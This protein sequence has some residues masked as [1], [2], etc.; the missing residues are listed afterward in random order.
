MIKYRQRTTIILLYI[1]SAFV[2]HRARAFYRTNAQCLR[3]EI[4]CTAERVG[5]MLKKV[6]KIGRTLISVIS[7]FIVVAVAVVILINSL[8]VVAMSKEDL[9]MSAEVGV[10][11]FEH[12]IEELCEEAV[13]LSTQFSTNGQVTG[14]MRSGDTSRLSSVFSSNCRDPEEV[15]ALFYNTT[16]QLVWKSSDTLDVADIPVPKTA[17]KDYVLG[18]SGTTLYYIAVTPVAGSGNI[19]VGVN[20][21]AGS[22]ID[23]IKSLVDAEVTVFANNVRLKTTIVD[24]NGDRVV[25]TTM[26]DEI[27]NI[28]IGK[29]QDYHGRA[30]ILGTPYYVM[31]EPI[32]DAN[33]NVVGALFAGFAAAESDATVFT[34]IIISAVVG[35]LVCFFAV[36]CITIFT[37][38]NIIAPVLA[39]KSL[40]DTMSR[41]ILNDEADLVALPK[42]E[43]GEMVKSLEETKKFL[44]G[45]ITDITNVMDAMAKGDFTRDAEIQ[46]LGNFEAI[47]TAFR[48]IQ[49]SLGEVVG[50]LND[51][52]SEVSS[53]SSQ[54]ANASQNLAEG[55]TR[56]AAA[57][58]NLSE[59]ISDI[60]DKIR[61][62]A[63][64]AVQ[65]DEYATDACS[66]VHIQAEYMDNMREA[67]NDIKIKS[68][69][70]EEIIKAIED[71]SFQTNIL[72]LNA[73]V[74]AARAGEAGKGF[75][76]VADEVRNLANK[77]NAATAQTAA[78][79]SETIA[80]VERGSEMVEK[81][82]ES[83]ADVSNIT[84]KTRDLI[85]KITGASTEQ[86]DAVH[87]V[88]AGISDIS[89][90]IQQNSATAEEIAASCQELSG[91]SAL[92][93]TQVERF[94]VNE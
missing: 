33:K 75:A 64:N 68:A 60:S 63:E 59:T 53:G 90:V 2:L 76:V 48:T 11:V 88:T 58:Q 12:R 84:E 34:T 41:G 89:D 32:Q 56:Q 91:Q 85:D 51:S 23:S 16:G 40:T 3:S 49:G 14:A 45:Y 10:K 46:Y 39:A 4:M 42:N 15:F 61:L 31:Y 21:A 92:L 72:A 29:A 71:I 74:E 8:R 44:S 35:L 80:A 67:M 70:I 52:A 37:K 22:Y 17:A 86:A 50:K 24:E 43:I 65:A 36:V 5:I 1:K 18:T 7:I 27:R 82:V 28:V 62:N 83:M 55:T 9:S 54:I 20:F 73:A 38:R 69:Q 66:K 87:Q 78:I 26:S 30:E 25:G 47:N 19:V 79:I 81:T 57:V 94:R 13:S 77:S 93:L 6:G